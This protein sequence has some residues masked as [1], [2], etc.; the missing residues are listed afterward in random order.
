MDVIWSID[1]GN[2]Q[3]VMFLGPRPVLWFSQLFWASRTVNG[4]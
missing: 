3:Q 4:I 2:R 1:I